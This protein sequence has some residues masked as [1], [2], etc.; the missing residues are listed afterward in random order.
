[1]RTLGRGS[2][3]SGEALLRRMESRR[4]RENILVAILAVLAVLG[5]G[6]TILGWFRTPPPGPS[7]QNTVTL[8]GQAQ[9]VE[10]FAREFVVTYLS[11]T[12][13]QQERIAQYVSAGQQITLPSTHRQV[14]DPMVVFSSR[15]QANGTVEVWTVTVSV[16][17][18][19]PAAGAASNAKGDNAPRQYY[20]V[21]IALTDGL[22]ALSV[23]AAVE[24]PA[25][26]A[27]MALAYETPCAADTQFA[28]VASGFVKAYLT[29][30]G[31]LNRYVALNSG[32]VA[33]QPPPF[34][35]VETASVSAD[36]PGCGT[37]GSTAEV[38]AMVN[39]KA[40][41]GVAP[42]LAYPLTLTRTAG[43]WQVRSVNPVPAL[44]NPMTL[45]T[46]QDSSGGGQAQS[47]TTTTAP[48]SAAA[49][50]PAKQN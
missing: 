38:L 21:G 32:I 50:P 33:P 22:R 46:G 14:S 8:L 36:E 45:V 26:G 41:D 48:S 3:D 1:M 7:D 34:T 49:V 16:R 13:D 39:P 44:R 10:S 25:R 27:D 30:S 37:S 6:G 5:G 11:A 20:R 4:R 2:T 47:N 12:N 28:Q 42:T 43:Q 40:A 31:D 35:S 15:K 24:P 17:P 9:L 18:G 23:P 19:N 29:G